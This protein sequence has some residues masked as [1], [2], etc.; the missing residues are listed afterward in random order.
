LR[1]YLK[2]SGQKGLHV[3]VGLVPEYTYQ[4][5]RMFAELVARIVATRIPDAATVNRE[6]A[7][8]KGRVYIDYLQLG[9]GKTI[10][11]P[12]TVRPVPGAPVSTPLRWDDLKSDLDPRAWNIKT[13]PARMARLKADPFLGALT[14]LQRLESALDR[15]QDIS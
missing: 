7:S 12:F 6:I 11:A 5:A 14:D 2:T 13:V 4:Q 9:H 1:P 10:A 8:R 15:I 3:L